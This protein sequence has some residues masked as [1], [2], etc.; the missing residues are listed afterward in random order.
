MAI[1][2]FS[3]PCFTEHLTRAFLEENQLGALRL[4]DAA[5]MCMR[6]FAMGKRSA[7]VKEHDLPTVPDIMNHRAHKFT[8]LFAGL[9]AMWAADM[10]PRSYFPE[11]RES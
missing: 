7:V 9:N 6:T 1:G 10:A 4:S 5:A 11:P 3:E 2:G 8:V